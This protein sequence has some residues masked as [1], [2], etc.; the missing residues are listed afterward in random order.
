MTEVRR[1]AREEGQKARLSV[2]VLLLAQAQE[3]GVDAGQAAADG[4]RRAVADARAERYAAA[5]RESVNAWNDYVAANG[6]PFE[7]VMEQPI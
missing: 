5:N 6:L 3:F 7:D 1:I 2:P 4:I